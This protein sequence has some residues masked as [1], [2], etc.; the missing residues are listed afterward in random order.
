MNL[1]A[2]RDLAHDVAVLRD[3]GGN[4]RGRLDDGAA[5]YRGEIRAW[6]SG[7]PTDP[8]LAEFL[9]SFVYRSDNRQVEAL[10]NTLDR[11]RVPERDRP[12]IWAAYE[13]CGSDGDKRV[14]VENVFNAMRRGSG[15]DGRGRR[16]GSHGR[17]DGTRRDGR[18]L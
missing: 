4:Y 10:Q 13:Q 5:R 8:R 1:R 6:I 11:A 16:D 2:V 15:G 17:V 9:D 18:E 7:G 12:P 14:F 3:A